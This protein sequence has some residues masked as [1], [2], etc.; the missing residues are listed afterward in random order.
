MP[1]IYKMILS[2]TGLQVTLLAW[3]ASLL[4]VAPDYLEFRGLR[5]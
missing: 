4:A 2:E 1:E 3:N 5:S